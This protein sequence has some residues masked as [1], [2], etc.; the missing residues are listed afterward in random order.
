MEDRLKIA[1]IADREMANP[2]ID[3]ARK[4][5]DLLDPLQ[6]NLA[7]ITTLDVELESWFSGSRYGQT[8]KGWWPE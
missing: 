2:W 4:Q 1:P 6:E 7:L 3:W 8:E 5:A